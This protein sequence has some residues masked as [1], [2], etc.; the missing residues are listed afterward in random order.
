MLLATLPF[1]VGFPGM[2][3]RWTI[4]ERVQFAA[5]RYTTTTMG[6][7]NTWTLVFPG[8]DTDDRAALLAGVTYH[9]L[10]FALFGIACI[11]AAAVA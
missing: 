8:D 10:G 1:D 4:I 6:A 9:Q 2:E 5:D 11:Y 3:T 7:Y